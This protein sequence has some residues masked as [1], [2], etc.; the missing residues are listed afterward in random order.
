MAK[1]IDEILDNPNCLCSDKHKAQIKIALAKLFNEMTDS[2]I[3]DDEDRVKGAYENDN[4]A[5]AWR[6]G[7]RSTQRQ[8]ADKLMKGMLNGK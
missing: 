3:G 2:I 1:T 6:N 8:R 5:K 4:D 7:L